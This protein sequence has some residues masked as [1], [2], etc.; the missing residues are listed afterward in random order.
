MR[1]RWCMCCGWSGL[2]RDSSGHQDPETGRVCL[3][4]NLGFIEAEESQPEIC[5]DQLLSQQEVSMIRCK[6]CGWT[7]EGVVGQRGMQAHHN[8][9]TGKTC[10]CPAFVTVLTTSQSDRTPKPSD[11]Q[12]PAPKINWR[13]FL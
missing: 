7:G 1:L 6:L 10:P 8:P 13:E 9:R 4:P 11:E 3:R 5:Q 2:E 12:K